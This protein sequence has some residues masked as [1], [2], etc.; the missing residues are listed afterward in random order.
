MKPSALKAAGFEHGSSSKWLE[1]YGTLEKIRHVEDRD[2][3]YGRGRRGLII[4][5]KPGVSPLVIGKYLL[6]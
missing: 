3:Y 2:H 6:E 4:R 5:K 1:T